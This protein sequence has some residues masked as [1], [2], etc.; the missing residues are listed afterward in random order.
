MRLSADP[1]VDYNSAGNLKDR[2]W[3]NADNISISPQ[4]SKDGASLYYQIKN[5]IFEVKTATGKKCII[6]T[7]DSLADIFNGD[8]P[9]IHRFLR[10]NDNGILCLAQSGNII[11]ILKI[12][13]QSISPVSRADNPF[14]IAPHKIVP[15]TQSSYNSE[16][17]KI[18]F[19][20]D[21]S[22]SV[23][24]EWIDQSR[25]RTKY[26]SLEPGQIRIQKTRLGHAFIAGDFAF[27]AKKEPAVAYLS[28]KPVQKKEVV[29]SEKPKNWSAEIKQNNLYIK[30][31]KAE[32]EIQL[33]TDGVKRWS[34]RAPFLWSPDGCFLAASKVKDGTRR[35]I[36]II[37]SAPPDQLQPRTESILY[38]KPGDILD[39]AKPHLFN[40][41]SGREVPLNQS[42]YSN[43]FNLS[44]WQW[45]SNGDR[46]FFVYNERGHQILR[47]LS[48]EAST[49]KVKTIVE[50]RSKTF[51]DYAHK[52]Y[53]NHLDLTDEAIWMSERSGWNHLY[54]INRSNGQ[55]RPITKGEWVVRSVEHVDAD[56]RQIYF[57]ASGILPGQDPYFIH[58]ARINF[59]GTGLAVITEANGTHSLQFSSDRKYFTDTWSRVD[60]PPVHELRRS[61]DGK[62]M[63]DL[64]SADISRL[65]KLHP[66]LPEPFVA[67][68][69]DGSTDIYGVLYRPI[70]FDP[71]KSYPVIESIYAGPHGYNVPKKFATYR[72]E[73]CFAELGFIVV[74]IDGM[75]TNWR[76][77]SFHDVCWKNLKDAGFP[78]RI[79]WIKSAARKY[80]YIDVTRV[81]IFGVSAGGQNAMRAV[82]DHADFYKAAVSDSGCHDNR[83]DK[84]WWNEAWMGWPV[85][86]SYI[87][88]S[89]VADAPK[90]KGKLLLTVG[91]QDINVDPSSTLQVVD[92]LIKAD[93]DFELIAF[94]SGGH[95]VAVTLYGMRRSSEFFVRH[96]IKEQ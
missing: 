82:I 41:T 93:K 44:E 32:K 64:G 53:V 95:G 2:L 90:L 37:H 27:F 68:G 25:C 56:K 80:P 34:Y 22:E 21:T 18:I 76:S 47:L 94:P 29:N 6:V 46:L 54:L 81:G 20:N 35:T 15:E 8:K 16:V 67:K 83:M 42:L 92:A 12:T 31:S 63:A 40:L 48:I 73:Q 23:D 84:I 70:N 9:V 75:G 17:S 14:V 71:K 13:S 33:T 62:K 10:A 72:R 77:K 4:W 87:K 85:D 52:T 7:A 3:G 39:I 60:K 38:A 66:H 1:V 43:P 36:D 79:A 96:L 45:S 11:K 51:I 65:L 50:E 30:N 69:R 59:D 5:Q 61:S 74:Q 49:G 19:V 91:M 28:S 89:N 88:N 58:Y 78:D 55:S 86:E 57:Y 26:A 24:I